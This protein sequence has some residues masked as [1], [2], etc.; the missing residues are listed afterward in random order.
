MFDAERALLRRF[1]HHVEELI[2]HN[3]SID[4]NRSLLA[5][6][7]VALGTVWSQAGFKEVRERVR[8]HH[9]EVVHFHNTFPLISPAGYY[10]A[11][12]EGAAVVQT[13]HNF[14]LG[15][16]NG[17]FMRE[18]KVCELC[19]GRQVAWPAV[20][21]RCYRGS[22][23]GSAAVVAM[24]AVHR[25][26]GTWSREV[27]RFI[28]LT[29][30]ARDKFVELGLPEDRLVVEPNF[31]GEDPGL[32]HGEGGFALFVGRLSEEKGIRVL[33]EAW[34]H[35]HSMP[36]VVVGDGELAGLVEAAIREGGQIEWRGRRGVEEILAMMKAAR[37]LIIPSICYEGLPRVLV[38]AAATGLP[39]ITSE[40]GSL[41][42]L[43]HPGVTGFHVPPGDALSLARVVN[44]FPERS[45]AV[46]LSQGARAEFE[47]RYT[48]AR[49]HAAL[50]STYT[51]A[52]RAQ[53][54]RIRRD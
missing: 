34:R 9:A 28:A 40:I 33:L 37:V 20:R 3:D 11:H 38:E 14:R 32:G 24:Q 12:A 23:A 41:H 1:G 2:F 17:L 10:A 19:I 35:V 15:C 22:A 8:R 49:H 31:L 54:P 21:H 51:A 53:R 42:E 25:V 45:E 36:L 6:V 50:I 18:G 43:V 16:A 48:A 27:D 46:A 44:A 30:F 29:T 13:L 7:P 52:V 4:D 39:V 26:L 47:A 5:G